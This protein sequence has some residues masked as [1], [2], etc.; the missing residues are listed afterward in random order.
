ML[1][2]VN[3][4]AQISKLTHRYNAIRKLGKRHRKGLEPLTSVFHECCSK[5]NVALN[6]TTQSR[7]DLEI[8]RQGVD[9][10]ARGLEAHSAA[11]DSGNF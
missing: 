10:L 9:G 2:V 4:E 3:L 6:K 11:Y 1:R 7:M 8:L 5:H